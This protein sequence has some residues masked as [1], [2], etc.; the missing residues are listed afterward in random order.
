MKN[1]NTVLVASN[2]DLDHVIKCNVFL[3]DMAHFTKMNEVYETYFKGELP[4]RTCVAVKQ[5]P[6]SG[7]NYYNFSPS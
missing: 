6:K 5:L 1:L 3:T 4:A 2:S 7:I